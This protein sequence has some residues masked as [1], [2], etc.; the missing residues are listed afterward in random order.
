MDNS[1]TDLRLN[2]HAAGA[3]ESF[4]PS[5]TDIMTVIV[6]IFLM[7]MLILLLRNMELLN[8]L[9]STMAAEQEA[10]ELVRSKGAE[11]ETLE[12]K[13]LSREHE[14]TMLSMQVMR[15]EEDANKNQATITSQHS[16]ISSLTLEKDKLTDQ[17]QQ[18]S[19]ARNTLNRQVEQLTTDSNLL[20]TQVAQANQNISALQVDLTQLRT[21]QD[22]TLKDL[23]SLRSAYQQKET[24]LETALVSNQEVDR[25]LTDLQREYASLKVKYD[26]LLRPAR[27]A[28]GK[29]VIEVRYT[30]SQ[31]R[32]LIECRG[33]EIPDFVTFTESELDQY[34]TKLKQQNPE[35]LYI[36]V[37]LPTDSGLSYNEAWSFTNRLHKT[38]DYYYQEEAQKERIEE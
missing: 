8:Q 20:R 7:A 24:A 1:F 12:E 6:V 38:Y 29:L 3:E 21:S 26:K 5:F 17:T 14:I 34:L 28:H 15:L 2:Q 32:F 25:L 9:R 11:N 16:Q 37:I 18:L 22:A 23:E 33:P 10:R 13:L 35:G 19:M 31:G 30:K 36:R 27:S 4:W